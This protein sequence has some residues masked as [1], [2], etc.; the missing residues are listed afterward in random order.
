MINLKILMIIDCYF[1]I[2]GGA[3]NQLRQLIPHL[4]SRNCAIT[5]ITRR[6][7]KHMA[8]K[9]IIDDITVY[10]I[11]RPGTSRLSAISYLWGLFCFVLKNRNNIDVIHTH[12]AAALGAVGKVL[13]L[14][15]R[16]RNVAKVS[17]AMR[18]PVLKKSLLG[19]FILGI[20]K[21]SDVIVC[22]SD[23]IQQQLNSIGTKP[24]H[25]ARIH[26]AVDCNRFGPLQ[27]NFVKNW[28]NKRDLDE[29]NLIVIYTGRLVVNKGLE[30]L[31]E[32]WKIIIRSCPN[33]YL[34]FLGDG[35]S[36]KFHY[37]SVE[38]ELHNK[39]KMEN[40]P[41][42]IFEGT[43]PEPEIYLGVSDIFAFPSR[44]EGLSNVLM[45]AMASGIGIVATDIGGNR[46]LIKHNESGLLV[47]RDNAKSLTD[48]I[49][50]L[51][52]DSE[53]RKS[54]GIKARELMQAHFSFEEIAKQ[55]Y[56]IYISFR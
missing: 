26:N 48:A 34:L 13:S 30:L 20:F 3:Q 35:S 17:S 7:E 10:R 41:Q 16:K 46:E 12:G 28:R 2:W 54:M 49:I 21:N 22:L 14:F 39:V 5:I 8:N 18:I 42:V 4:V 37:P 6:W 15:I 11:G 32:A 47:P 23:E 31:L 53:K 56:N 25:I 51:A 45:E 24:E 50:S 19:K 43:S 38:K 33:A 36:G 44:Q 55:Y 27:E 29:N 52:E 40:I 1:P 9:D